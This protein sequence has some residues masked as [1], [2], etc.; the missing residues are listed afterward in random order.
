MAYPNST[1]NSTILKNT[2]YEFLIFSYQLF[3]ISGYMILNAEVSDIKVPINMA[4][5]TPS[6]YFVRIYIDNKEVKTFKI[7]KN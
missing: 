6:T 3:N 4:E 2:N 7:I 5:F 1:S